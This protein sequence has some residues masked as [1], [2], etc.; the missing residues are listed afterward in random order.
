[1]ADSA[2]PPPGDLASFQVHHLAGEK[3]GEAG[4][5]S[6]AQDRDQEIER[7]VALGAQRVD[8]GQTGEESIGW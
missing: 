3:F 6:S 4:V 5:T 2:F 1:M 8:I 7:L